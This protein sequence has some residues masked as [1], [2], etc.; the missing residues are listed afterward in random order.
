M[1]AQW[2]GQVIA[3]SDDIV[4]V[5]GNM[6]TAEPHLYAIGD[7]IGGDPRLCKIRLRCG[8]ERRP[9]PAADCVSVYYDVHICIRTRGHAMTTSC[10]EAIAYTFALTLLRDGC[11]TATKSRTM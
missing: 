7:I 8:L 9:L 5:D 4:K 3:S 10:A 11:C 2:N 1:Q 6:Q